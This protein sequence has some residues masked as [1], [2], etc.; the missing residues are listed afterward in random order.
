MPTC[1]IIAGPNGAGKTT[2]AED[3]LP[4]EAQTINF[5]NAD[6][7]AKGLSPFDSTRSNLLAAKIML[8]RMDEFVE[9]LVDFAFE[10][11]LSGTNYIR[12]IQYWKTLG[13]E[14]K[15][16]FLSLP[17]VEIAK[18]RVSQRVLEG[19]H[20]I[21]KKTIER[22]FYKGLQNLITYKKVI[23]EWIIYDN[24]GNELTAI[25]YGKND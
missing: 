9:S 18:A 19:G 5:L 10:T 20:D 21:P 7:I 25:D 24:S 14:T 11:T 17:D 8:R 4:I 3:F 13:Y 23:D 2:F 6:L 15:L 12:K 16:I 1:Y 22:R